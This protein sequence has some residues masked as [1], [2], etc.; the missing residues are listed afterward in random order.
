[1]GRSACPRWLWLNLT[2]ALVWQC[3][4]LL[5]PYPYLLEEEEEVDLAEDD[6]PG[7]WTF[8]FDKTY[9]IVL[10]GWPTVK[11][12]AEIADQ[13]LNNLPRAQAAEVVRV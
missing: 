2:P 6:E 4:E 5:K 13:H 1:M 11:S 9:C 12:I 8:L 10:T 3:L 7:T